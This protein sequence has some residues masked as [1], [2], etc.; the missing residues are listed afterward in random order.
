MTIGKAQR[1]TVVGGGLAGCECSY[2][3]AQYGFQ[4]T[5]REQKPTTR[6]PAHRYDGLAELVCSNS[7]RSDNPTNAIGLLHEEL[8]RLDS[9]VLRIADST[10][11]PAGDA[12]A[13]DREA[14][15]RG[16]ES[17]VRDAGIEVVP[18]EVLEIP[19]GTVVVA[20]G[21]L[22][23]DRFAQALAPWLGDRLAFYDAIAPIVADDSI[24]KSIAFAA[25]RYGKG[26]A[27][28]LNL[29]M[30]RQEYFAFVEELKRGISVPPHAFEEPKYFEG[31]L[32]VE[33]LAARGEAALAFGP[34]K[35]VGLTDPRT[36]LRP[37]AVVQLRREDQ[38]G[39]AWN[40]VGFQT[41]L[42]WPEQRRIFSTI[43]GLGRAEWIRMGQIHR[44][45]FIDSPRLLSRDL[46]LK[47]EPR[48]F[49]AGQIS[50]VEG[51]VESAAS[52]LLVAHA[53]S[54]RF[55]Q[56][57]FDAPPEETALGA[58][59]RHVI[60]EAH[61]HGATFQPTNVVYSLFPPI[62]GRLRKQDRKAAHAH[63]AQEGIEAWATGAMARRRSFRMQ[64]AGAGV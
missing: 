38:A 39:T 54:A 64:R 32:P 61:P 36:G 22:T 51:Y 25:S 59:Y 18:G 42:T 6:S 27:D 24:D 35:P 31:C 44:N 53:I 11:V 62:E 10:R 1:I 3:L 28:Y 4:V 37:F 8:R 41:R 49:F 60:G 50:G 15:S 13:V 56:T 16:V 58:L 46:S 20:T 7:F 2:Q 21:P 40:L 19:S 17:A 33:V 29:P 23:S 5:L 55:T 43:P 14:F 45:T 47:S 12:L 63:R 9:L 26:G 52:G 30:D 48:L 34:M 57:E